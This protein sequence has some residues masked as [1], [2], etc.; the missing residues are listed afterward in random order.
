[1]SKKTKSAPGAAPKIWERCEIDKALPLWEMN[2]L[3][4][5]REHAFPARVK[6]SILWRA[7]RAAKMLEKELE[8][9]LTEPRGLWG[10]AKA[11]REDASKYRG[12]R[13]NLRWKTSDPSSPD[14][15]R[16]RV[17]SGVKFHLILVG[18][19][20][21]VFM[22]PGPKSWDD[23]PTRYMRDAADHLLHMAWQLPNL[24]QE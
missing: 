5:E 1:M 17:L 2:T 8:A 21:L 4:E 13:T 18:W 6:E 19:N 20:L 10:S 14:L 16:G 7:E 12:P 11:V 23:T 22:T 24:R 3:P 15:A 9:E